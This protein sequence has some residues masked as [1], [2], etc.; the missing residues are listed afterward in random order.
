MSGTSRNRSWIAVALIPL[1]ALTVGCAGDGTG[2]DQFGNPLSADKAE[3]GPTLSSIQRNVFTPICTQ[4]HTGAAGPLGLALDEGAS[5]DDLVNVP[6]VEHTESSYLVW[7]VEGRADITGGRMPL[8][9]PPLSEDE[10]AAIRG[11][12]EQGAED[13]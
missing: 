2:L 6:S 7:K 10:I 8:G 3:L 1:A 5:R 12:I 9:L 4:C 13:N 11:W